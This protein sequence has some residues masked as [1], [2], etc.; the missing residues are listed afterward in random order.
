MSLVQILENSTSKR[1]DLFTWIIKHF[2][3]LNQLNQDNVQESCIKVHNNLNEFIRY[4]ASTNDDTSELDSHYIYIRFSQLYTLCLFRLQSEHKGKIFDSAE[5][6]TNVLLEEDVSLP[7]KEAEKN[8]KKSPPKKNYKYSASKDLASTITTQLFETFGKQLT[9][10]KL[11]LFSAIFKNLKKI[12]EK[13]KYH[14][15]TYM[16]SLIQLLNAILRSSSDFNLDPIY[17]AKFSKFSKFIFESITTS[18]QDFP[19]DFISVLIETWA[20]YLKQ[21]SYFKDHQND[22]FD[23]IYK[24][25][26]DG[27]LGIYG[28]SNDETRIYTAKS[29]AEILFHCYY[30]K[31]VFTLKVVWHLYVKLFI[32]ASTRD[33]KIA[34]FESIVHYIGLCNMTNK[35]FLANSNYLDIIHSLA[36]IF[37]PSVTKHLPLSA[38]MQNITFFNILHE[39]ILPIMGDASKTQIL[40]NII[41]SIEEDSEK[42]KFEIKEDWHQ[43]LILLDLNLVH[44][45]L[46]ILSSSF[47]ADE[48]TIQQMKNKL[49][50]LSVCDNFTIRVHA[51]EVLKVFLTAFP[52]LITEV[53]EYSLDILTTDF[54]RTE[55]FPFSRNHGNALIIATLIEISNKDYVAYELIMKITVF[56]TSFIKNNTTS[57]SVNLYYKGLICWILLIGLMNYEDDQYIQ[58]QSSQL[59]LFWKVLLTHTFTYH[60][61]D[62]LYKNL[63]IR[64]HALTCLLTYLKHANINV[65]IAKQISYLLT[66]C[67]NFNNSVSLKSK[68]I[69]RA[70]LMNEN[71]IIQIYLRIQVH[72]KQDFNSSLLI[73][74]VKNFSDPKLYSETPHSLLNTIKNV[75]GKKKSPKT[76]EQTE[77]HLEKSVDT[78]LRQNDDFAFGLSSKVSKTGIYNLVY[79]KGD[80]TFQEIGNNWPQ[81]KEWYNAYEN[82]IVKPVQSVLSLDSLVPLYSMGAYSGNNKYAPKVTTSLIDASIELF[83]SVFPYLNSKIQYS[84]LENLNLSM[85]T[86]LTSPLRSV[87]IAANVCVAIHN[88]L[89]VMQKNDLD[90]EQSVGNLLLESLKKLEFYND[91]YLTSLKADCIGLLVSAIGKGMAEPQ[92]VEFISEQT[93]IFVKVVID[94]EEPYSRIFHALSLAAIFKYNPKA[95]S[96]Y[97]IFDT[98]FSLINDPHPVVHSWSLKAMQ[99]LIEEYLVIEISTLSKLLM[100][101]EKLLSD[102][103][104]GLYGSSFLRYNYNKEFNSHI[105]IGQIVETLT[106]ITGPNFKLL[107]QSSLDCF[108]NITVSA[109]L[110]KDLN[111][112]LASMSIFENIA[113]FKL[114]DILPDN[115]FVTAAIKLIKNSLAIGIGSSYYNPMFVVTNELFA[116]SS[117]LDASFAS[118]RL[119]SQLSRLLKGDLFYVK[120]ESYSWFYFAQY[121]TSQEL[122]DYFY[123]WLLHSINKDSHVFAK[124]YRFFNISRE[125]LS[126]IYYNDID[127]LLNS[128]GLKLLH[129]E[130]IKGEEEESI[131]RNDEIVNE[132]TGIADTIN[133]KAKRSIVKLVICL[134]DESM[135]N[136]QIFNILATKI[137]ELIKISFKASTMRVVSMKI[138]GLTLLNTLLVS[139]SSISDSTQENASILNQQEAQITGAL[140]PAFGKGSSPDAIALAVKVAAEIISS[141]IIPSDRINKIAELLV[142]LLADFN[143]S[144]A[145]LLVGEVQILTQKAKRRVELA[146]LDA[147]ASILYRSVINHREAMIE[148]TRKYLKTLVPLWIISLREYMMV[149]YEHFSTT[150]E[151]DKT[152][153][154]AN[155]SKLAMYEP[156][157]LNFVEA[158][159]CILENDETILLNSLEQD[160][161]EGFI[162]I[163]FVQCLEA[164]MKNFDSHSLKVQLLSA[165]HNVLKCDIPLRIL[166][167]DSINSELIVILDRLLSTSDRQET[168]LTIEVINDIISQYTTQKLGHVSFLQDI[169]KLYELLRLLMS[170]VSRLLPFIK[171]NN[172][173]SIDYDTIKLNS[174]DQLLLKRVFALFEYNI[175]RFNSMFKMDLYAC[176]LYIIGKVYESE[177]KDDII[178][179]VLPLLKGISKDIIDNDQGGDLLKIFYA[180]MKGTIFTNVNVENSLATLFVL[181]TNGYCGFQSIDIEN[182]VQ[183]IIKNISNTQAQPIIKQGLKRIA[184]ESATNSTSN[185]ILKIL[186]KNLYEFSK[187]ASE[188]DAK[189][190][191][192]L[193]LSL[194]EVLVLQKSG[195]KKAIFNMN[196]IFILELREV[197]DVNDKTTRDAIVNLIEL[198]QAV[199]KEVLISTLTPEQRSKLENIITTDLRLESS[200]SDGESSVSL[201]KFV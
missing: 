114:D 8:R 174:E 86:K 197:S 7:S 123:E 138:L 181:L 24:K 11:N 39:T 171:Y 74:I 195:K 41:D 132:V 127:N 109:L 150:L 119:L 21:D 126:Q 137:P 107:D 177:I 75:H 5:L 182:F 35:N 160:E 161:I 19:V 112:Q 155:D 22:F 167:E 153:S 20:F 110:S 80:A 3:E 121:P 120:L 97:P 16:T 67:S 25:F 32:N 73:L 6:L 149:K 189:A 98:L 84:V 163:L 162:F 68:N 164:I 190:I 141:D 117:S 201:K 72:I 58:M 79:H 165:M 89:K 62:E 122:N 200:G 131:A 51:I 48:R 118:F 81:K 90:L 101:L 94:V 169:D 99:A 47:G 152:L 192:E 115:I 135:D 157:W 50:L 87:A 27:E 143:N 175:S 106:E 10:L 92:R 49:I 78:L 172:A 178:P 4:L 40:F 54:K 23:T 125:A 105:V 183:L 53:M 116:N 159:A 59:F 61:E 60:N 156:I 194:T 96:F 55:D 154:K 196:L 193:L 13:S 56:A 36:E 124:L 85:F 45:L 38:I 83:S 93:N 104:F 134:C 30:S 37:N 46:D 113:T 136:K 144:H 34:C 66:K 33:T 43:W 111:E 71:R 95:T 184:T 129:T 76:V 91:T 179:I 146:V 199:F 186:I 28:F 176:L 139:F 191:L 15:A 148:E 187:S 133:W 57:L 26:S 12:T 69:D 9:S 158:L 65:E 128:H 63:E 1:H 130:E 18:E 168:L 170:V 31:Q 198:D 102:P 147:W 82:E 145:T 17:A 77:V 70:L 142:S 14:H 151:S 103:S 185:V 88:A 42:K 173:V 52:E 29:L 100:T 44:L 180:S 166:F 188:I 64:N 140:M 108:R 2:D